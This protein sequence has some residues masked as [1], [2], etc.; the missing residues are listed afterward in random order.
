MS[1]QNTKCQYMV[2]SHLHK[3][4]L[5]TEYQPDTYSSL[6]TQRP[7]SIP[8]TCKITNKVCKVQH[9]YQ[10]ETGFMDLFREPDVLDQFISISFS[11]N[12]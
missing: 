8:L 1:H 5:M 9:S 6:F 7:M 11:H 2:Y 4:E 12:M 3:T 10:L